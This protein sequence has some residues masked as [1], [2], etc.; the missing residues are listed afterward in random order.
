MGSRQRPRILLDLKDVLLL[1]A[2]AIEAYPLECFGFLLGSVQG[3]TATVTRVLNSSRTHKRGTNQHISWLQQPSEEVYGRLEDFFGD[4]L[5][6]DYHSHPSSTPTLSPADRSATAQEDYLVY[7][8]I[9]IW[10]SRR[11]PFWRFKL[12]GYVREGKRL[13][14]AHI[15]TMK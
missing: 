2:A 1:K 7:L 11:K 15:L 8:V 4:G 3:N 10:P 14:T 6:G 12:G 5:I 9:G 13:R